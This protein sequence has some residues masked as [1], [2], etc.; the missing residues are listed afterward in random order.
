VA[1]A[2]LGQLDSAAMVIRDLRARSP[3]HPL[4]M[5]IEAELASLRGDDST[6]LR[7]AVGMEQV[8]A[9]TVIME[10]GALT[11]MAASRRAGR[12]RESYAARLRA[13]RLRAARGVTGEGSLTALMMVDDRATLLGD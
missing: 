3:Y 10:W 4:G 1:Y 13:E 12:L 8:N 2:E 11:R 6:A 5:V 9:S 7:T